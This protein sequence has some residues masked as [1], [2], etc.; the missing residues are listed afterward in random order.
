[1]APPNGFDISSLDAAEQAGV[2][3]AKSFISEGSAY[4]ALHST[5]PATIGLAISSSP[6]ALLAWIGEKYIEWSDGELPLHHILD[7]AS[8]YWLTDTFPRSIFPYRNGGSP[9]SDLHSSQE[10]FLNIPMGY[11]HFPKDIA[12][13]PIAWVKTTGNLIWHN[14]HER[15]G[16]FA[17]LECPEAFVQDVDAFMKH[18]LENSFER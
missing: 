3:R 11:S 2:L 18:L 14:H 15:G 4:A 10:Y 5:R 13:A 1:M 12:P 16:H 8:L 7:A 17:S 9:P 6:L